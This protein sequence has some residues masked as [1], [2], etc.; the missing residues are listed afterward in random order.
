MPQ[1]TT[2]GTRQKVIEK[3]FHDGWL[4]VT[5]GNGKSVTWYCQAHHPKPAPRPPRVPFQTSQAK[6]KNETKK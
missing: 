3:A 4:R 2:C 6:K 5:G 1:C